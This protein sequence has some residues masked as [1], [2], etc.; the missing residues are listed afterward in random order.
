MSEG[1]EGK[2]GGKQEGFA[3]LFESYSAGGV[4]N[5]DV[6]AK[7]KGEIISIGKESVFIQLGAKSDG[8]VEKVELF[9]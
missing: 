5:F 3:E 7:V 1:E 6:G 9:D 4:E 2:N 8:V